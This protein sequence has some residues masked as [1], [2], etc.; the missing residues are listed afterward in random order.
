MT[1][2]RQTL[3]LLSLL[4]S[5]LVLSEA[6]AAHTTA[7]DLQGRVLHVYDGDT[8]LVD[9]IGKVRLV[10][11]DAPEGEASG[12]DDFYRRWQISPDRLRNI[13][14][15]AKE[16]CLRK[17]QSGPITLTP[18]KNPRDR[19]GR[20]LAYVRLTDGRLLNRLLLERGLATVYRRFDFQ[21][22][23]DFLLAENEARRHGYGLWQ[24]P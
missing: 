17:T 18:A 6:F 13:A 11:I 14:W 21:M 23:Q 3:L 2:S 9:G 16:F 7:S 8:I 15:R 4:L 20:L 10:G 19:Y 24:R 5:L 1:F 12:R 22:K